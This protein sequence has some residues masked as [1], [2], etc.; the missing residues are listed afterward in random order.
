MLLRISHLYGPNFYL[1][2]GLRFPEGVPFQIV[3]ISEDRQWYLVTYSPLNQN[4]QFQVWVQAAII[5]APSNVE[6]AES[7]QRQKGRDLSRSFQPRLQR[8][9]LAS[10]FHHLLR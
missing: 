3:G 2:V 5:G 8:R 10:R 7:L 9:R 1:G 4:R 6:S